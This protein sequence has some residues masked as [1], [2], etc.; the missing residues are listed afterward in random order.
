MTLFVF[1]QKTLDVLFPPRCMACEHAVDGRDA[2][3]LPCWEKVRFLGNAVCGCCG[4]PLEGGDGEALCY[5]CIHTPKPYDKARAVVAYEGTVRKVIHHFKFRDRTHLAP[6]LAR[7]MERAG[8]N[9]LSE[10]DV[11]VPVP[12]HPL[13]MM[14]RKY[15]Q[16]L[17]LAKHLSTISGIT[18][19]PRLLQRK[20]RTKRQAGLGVAQRQANVEGAFSVRSLCQ[21]ALQGKTVLLVDDVMTTGATLEACSRA[22][23]KAGAGKVHV[24]TLARTALDDK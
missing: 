3:C 16:A 12:L 15:N 19:M 8:K 18:L 1:A 22:L 2:F 4:L 10:A 13:R 20:K 11:I 9:L 21:N 5:A 23:L 7:W 24:L 6:V 14:A 17:L